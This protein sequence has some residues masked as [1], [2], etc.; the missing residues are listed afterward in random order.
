M[1]LQNAF[2]WLISAL[3]W[4]MEPIFDIAGLYATYVGGAA[5][6][7]LMGGVAVR[8]IGRRRP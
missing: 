6:L 2:S 4:L 3:L 7:L 8:R 5:L 1:I